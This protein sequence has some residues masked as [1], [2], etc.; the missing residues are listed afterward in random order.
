MSVVCIVCNQ[1]QPDEDEAAENGDT[2]A[3]NVVGMNSFMDSFF[4]QVNLSSWV[5]VY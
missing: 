2:C 1:A 4:E 3:V 5:Y